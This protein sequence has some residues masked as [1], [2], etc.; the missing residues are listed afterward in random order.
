MKFISFRTGGAAHYG[1]VE[2]NKVIDLTP[3]LKHS[4]LR[5][6]LVAGAQAEA[7]RAAKGATADFTLDQ[8]AFDPVIPNPD[9]IV[10]I[11]LNYEGHLKETGMTR[12]PY[13]TIFP[14][15]ADSQVGHLAPMVKPNDSEQ[16]DYEGELAVVIGKRG[17]Y[18][19][20]SGAASYV[21]GYACYNEGSIRD[22]QRHASQFTPGKNFPAT[23]AFG[24]FLVTPDEVGTVPDKTIETRLNGKTVQSSVLGDMIFPPEQLIEY[25]SRFTPLSPGD[26][27]VTGTPAG[28][29]WV[30]KPPLWMKPGD[31]VEVEIA[32]VG[33]L[34]NPI[35]AE[36]WA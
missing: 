35:R 20:A 12:F 22:W 15:W 8:I 5:A 9:K 27:I 14:R 13:P 17:R 16:Y 10:C 33:L 19:K 29:G 18:I 11:G 23:G 26:V 1:L 31:T 28:V 7:A 36:D 3:R 25:I 32:N 4:D 34:R 30:R 2:G 21:A 6:L 24:P